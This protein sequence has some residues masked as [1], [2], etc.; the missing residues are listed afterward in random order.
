MYT[1]K[2]SISYDGY[3]YYGSQI[4]SSEITIQ[5]ELERC[6][7]NM[8][9]TYIKTYFASRTDK[10][11]HAIS[12]VVS[13]DIDFEIKDYK[14]FIIGI[15]KRLPLDIRVNKIVRKNNDFHAR[16]SAKFKIYKYVISKNEI[17]PF[18]S[19]YM[20]Y[21]KNINID[22]LK[23]CIDK[24]VGIHDFT[25]FSKVVENRNPIKNLLYIKII[26]SK[27]KITLQF[28]GDKFL[29]YMIRKIVSTIISISQGIYDISIIDKIFLT[30][31]PKLCP[32]TAPAQGLYLVNVLYK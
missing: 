14:N 13:I 17:S 32:H 20:A 19:R 12:Q 24:V 16:H 26:E 6:L 11:V 28:K 4:Q 25:G 2:L 29:R 23:K 27:N 1:Y 30:K 31:D 8:T 18:Q 7:R 22:I 9:Q 3:S 21:Y 5:R 10:K 15:N